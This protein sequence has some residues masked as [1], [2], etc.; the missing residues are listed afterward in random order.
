M[1]WEE[2][3]KAIGFIVA[4]EAKTSAKL[5]ALTEAQNRN[6]EGIR[7]LLAIAEVHEREIMA[8]SQQ[9]AA[10]GEQIL[11]L[12]EN[13]RATDERLNALVNVVERM[14]SEGRNGRS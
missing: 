12:G 7:A 13:T 4:Q 8:H 11:A 1:T 2:I 6:A 3:E 14:I 10:N 5:D 9:I